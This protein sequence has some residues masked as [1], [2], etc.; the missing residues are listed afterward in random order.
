MIQNDIYREW[1]QNLICS[2][3][4]M[5][6]SMHRVIDYRFTPSFSGQFTL[7]LQNE[8]VSEYD[9]RRNFITGFQ[10]SAGELSP[11][12]C[13]RTSRSQWGDLCYPSLSLHQ[14]PEL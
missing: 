13:F 3:T 1:T 12:I 14:I 4:F 11:S 9:A 6:D 8:Y 10:G 5:R 2:V 7:Y